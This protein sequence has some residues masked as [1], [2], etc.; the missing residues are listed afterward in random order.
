MRAENAVDPAVFPNERSIDKH[1]YTAVERLSSDAAG[2]AGRV[3]AT[4]FSRERYFSPL[5]MGPSGAA[6]LHPALL[7]H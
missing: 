6:A 4:G 7:N 3:Q 5:R 1:P 2:W